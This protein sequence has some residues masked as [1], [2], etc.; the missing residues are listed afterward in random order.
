[1]HCGGG[2]AFPAATARDINHGNHNAKALHENM[3][4]VMTGL[5]LARRE[6]PRLANPQ[7]NR[8]SGLEKNVGPPRELCEIHAGK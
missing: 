7:W 1:M 4:I 3:L 2:G 8:I 5:E 6:L